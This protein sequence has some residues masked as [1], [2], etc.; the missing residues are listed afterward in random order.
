MPGS[1]FAAR[2]QRPAT[3]EEEAA[4]AAA[5]GA[6]A[7]PAEPTAQPLRI[8]VAED[9]LVNQM[10]IRK[11]LQRVVPGASLE[12]VGNG[13]LALEAALARR[14][15]LILMDIH[16]PEMDGIEAS[17]RLHEAL[18]PHTAPVVVALSADTLQMQDPKCAAAGFAA[19]I[20][21]PFRV[22]DVERVLR[23]VQH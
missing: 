20:C 21:K 9:N 1:P 18:P 16:M 7:E 5:P 4:A 8:L 11:V 19:F 23:L 10:V 15:D 17:R 13:A 22:E 2:A 6:P 12:I 3:P 14:P